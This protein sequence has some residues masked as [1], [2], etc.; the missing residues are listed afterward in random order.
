MAYNARIVA[1]IAAMR[2][3]Q[4][5]TAFVPGAE[6]PEAPVSEARAAWNVVP[7]TI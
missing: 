6:L 7:V 5:L 3:P 2:A 1:M 4:A